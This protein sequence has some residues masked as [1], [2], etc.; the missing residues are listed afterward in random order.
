MWLS[1]HWTWGTW[2]WNVVVTVVMVISI[3]IAIAIPT[4]TKKSKTNFSYHSSRYT[5]YTLKLLSLDCLSSW[6]SGEITKKERPRKTANLDQEWNMKRSGFSCLIQQFYRFILLNYLYFNFII[7]LNE[8]PGMIARLVAFIRW[9][10]F[11]LAS[12]IVSCIWVVF[13]DE[14]YHFKWRGSRETRQLF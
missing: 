11:I 2:S 8:P 5:W 10:L 12:G 4:I 14:T 1:S 3:V 9:I 6:I 7:S 13:I